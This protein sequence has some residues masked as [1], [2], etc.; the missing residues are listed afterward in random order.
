M[1]CETLGS[2]VLMEH[3]AVFPP[4]IIQRHHNTLQT[5]HSLPRNQRS[6]IPNLTIHLSRFF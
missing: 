6:S 5:K 3:R 1:I 4:S 2:N